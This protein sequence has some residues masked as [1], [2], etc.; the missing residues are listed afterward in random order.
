MKKLLSC[1]MLTF[2][3]SQLFAGGFQLNVQSAR[4]LGLGGANTGFSWGTESVFFN[5]G[6]MCNLKGH[7]FTFGGSYI[8]PLVSLQTPST[9]NINQT[10]PNSTPIHFYYGGEIIENLYAG[11]SINNQFGSSSSFDDDWEGRFIVQNISLKTFTFQPT[12]AYKIHDYISIG[13]GFMYTTGNFAI[14]KAVPVGSTEFDYGKAKLSGKGT[15]YG[16]NVGI[17]STLLDN[18]HYRIT[19]G[20]SYRS[21]QTL[22]LKSGQAEFS[23]IPV[24][25]QGTFPT[26]T[27]F[28]GELKLPSVITTGISAQY[29]INDKNKLTLVYDFNY[30]GWSSYDTL[31]FDFDNTDT[32][33]SKTTKAWKNTPTHRFGLEYALNDMFF[34]RLGGYY[35]ITPIQD[36]FVSP[37]LPDQTQFV[38]TFGFGMMIKDHVGFDIAWIHQDAERESD[39]TD[40]GF[41]AKYHRV[42]D[43]ITFSAT[44]KF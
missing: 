21:G 44:I 36:G 23:D 32:P 39:L 10:S 5:P 29:K 20:A 22:S 13:A 2:G 26:S 40:A 43:V 16:F 7:N 41:T 14:E 9:D 17:F 25:L 27:A 18:D 1:I 8:M 37:E 3:A 12:V 34:F 30:T 42:A 33:D 24:S 4:S 15:T 6:G 35:D 31:A 11:L 38:P 19:F 28:T